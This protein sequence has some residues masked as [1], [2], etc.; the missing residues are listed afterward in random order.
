MPSA[1]VSGRG[2]VD[3]LKRRA[4]LARPLSRKKAPVHARTG[5]FAFAAAF[6]LSGKTG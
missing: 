1:P 6:P 2:R 5:A 3:T 4:G